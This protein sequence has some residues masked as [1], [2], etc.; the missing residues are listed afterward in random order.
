MANFTAKFE[1]ER[2]DKSGNI[3]KNNA[4]DVVFDTY[5][6]DYDR[7]TVSRVLAAKKL[8]IMH[9]KEFSLPPKSF[10]DINEM[11]S[12]EVEKRAFNAIL[13]KQ[14]DNGGFENYDV[15]L[16]SDISILDRLTGTQY[17][18]LMRCQDDFFSRIGLQ[19]NELM[20]QSI[21]ILSQF[22][23]IMKGLTE[24]SQSTGSS[25]AEMMDLVMTAAKTF[26]S[27]PESNSQL[28][29]TIEAGSTEI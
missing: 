25:I 8:F 24:A 19:S 10:T 9:S 7:L 14:M 4:G 22:G 13:M 26:D 18:T 15:S 28:N 20:M 1:I 29:S 11:L 17:D 2:T 21:G 6:Y 27:Q 23:D 16:Q 5:I 3:I 12:R